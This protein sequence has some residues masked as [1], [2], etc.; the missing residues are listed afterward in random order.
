MLKPAV[1]VTGLLLVFLFSRG[2]C[3]FA[4]LGYVVADLQMAQWIC[5]TLVGQFAQVER[6]AYLLCS[7]GN[8][9]GQ[10]EICKPKASACFN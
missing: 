6:Q 10:V 8:C 4:D 7:L 9:E 5:C 2:R 3:T 1:T